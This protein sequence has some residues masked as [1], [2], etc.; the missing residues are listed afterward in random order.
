ML[1]SK[2]RH[3]RQIVLAIGSDRRGVLYAV[4]ENLRRMVGRGNAVLFPAELELPALRGGP[5]GGWAFRRGSQS[6]S[7]P[8]RASGR[9]PS[10]RAH[11]DYALAGAN[12]FELD[13][14]N[15]RDGL[16]DFLK[17]TVSTRWP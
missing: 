10:C 2:N 5:C 6:G 1:A 11:L 15:D 13:E 12:T 14:N 4:G 8:G 9:R 16:F 7:S 17:G 3:G